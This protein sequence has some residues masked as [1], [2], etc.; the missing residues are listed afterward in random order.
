MG[1]HML[2]LSL[3]F[4]RKSKQQLFAS[5]KVVNLLDVCTVLVVA[6]RVAYQV[7]KIARMENFLH[8]LPTKMHCGCCMLCSFQSLW[9]CSTLSF[10]DGSKHFSSCKCV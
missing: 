7:V 9:K 6:V 3:Y 8:Q 10:N 2:H 5:P 1:L 4:H